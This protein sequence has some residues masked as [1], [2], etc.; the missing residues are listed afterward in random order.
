MKY[1]IIIAIC[2]CLLL[3]FNSNAQSLGRVGATS[4]T[5]TPTKRST[6]LMGGG[7]DVDAAFKW[8]INRSGGGDFVVIRATGTNAYNSYIYGLGGAHSVETFL[9]SSVAQANDSSIVQAIRKAEAIFFAGGN[10][11]DYITDYKGT[12]LGAVID[13]IANVKQAPIGGTSAGDAIQGYVYYDGITNVLS[14]DVLPN[15]YASGTGIHYNDF[16]HNPYLPKTICEP[17]F[18]TKGGTTSNGITGRQGRLMS[19]LARMIKD[20]SMKDVKGIACDE[21]TAVCVDENGLGMVVGSSKA[22]FLRQW[23]AG[24]E[25]CVSGSPLTWTNGA[26]VYV[27]SGP[28]NITTLP[29][30][31]K[32]VNLTDWTTVTGGAYEFWTVNNGVLTIGQKTGTPTTCTLPVEEVT[33]TLTEKENGLELD[34]KTLNEIATANFLVQRSINGDNNFETIATIKAKG[35][36]NN[37]YSFL[38]QQLPNNDALKTIYY[39]IISQDDDGK[40]SINDTKQILLQH[41]L[42]SITLYPNPAAVSCTIEANSIQQIHVIDN[43]GRVVLSKSFYT[44]IQQ[45]C[46]QL[47]ALHKGYYTLQ[48]IDK[49]GNASVKKLIVE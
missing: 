35:F 43:L 31:N 40:E 22:F 25:T 4:D 26:R 41:P 14:T 46:L 21:A 32:S 29:N 30:T 5:I 15:P 7:T 6:V 36:N 2:S 17:H 48:I 13:Y 3:T 38:D 12:A 47:S 49:N 33:L 16:L 45:Y 8:M 11:N 28:G 42:A 34:W 18:L 37:E 10:Q 44:A 20:Q 39:R 9:V 1:K 19:F 23:C 27:V 24:P